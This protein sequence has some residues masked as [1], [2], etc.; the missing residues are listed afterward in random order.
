MPNIRELS[1]EAKLL[2][3]KKNFNEALPLYKSIWAESNIKNEWDGL[4]LAVC[5]KHLKQ[6]K[7]A[8]EICNEVQRLFPSFDKINTTF[9]WCIY[10]TEIGIEQITDKQ[11]LFLAGERIVKLSKQEDL[12]SNSENKFPCVRSLSIFKILQYLN[13]NEH[14]IAKDIL[15]WTEKLNP[16]LL[17]VKPFKF[18]KNGKEREIAPQKEQ[19]YSLRAKAFY[20]D[21]QF[22]ECI[23]FANKALI[24]FKNFHYDNNLWF[25][26]DIALSKA[27]LGDI[28]TALN[29]LK[30]ILT[31]KN[32]W[33]IQLEIAQ[34]FNKRNN[35]DEALKYA[36][37]AVLNF[38]DSKMK[39]KLYQLLAELLTKK[40]K[41]DIAKF[42]IELIY[43][44]RKSNKW[45]INDEL[46]KLLKEYEINT[47]IDLN[48]NEI[49][50]KLKPHWEQL[51]VGNQESYKGIIRTMISEGRAGFID[52]ENKH[53]YYF[54][55]KDFNG[56]NALAKQGQKVLFFLEDGYD[57]KKEQPT[58]I[59][60]N[61]R[62]DK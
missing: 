56:N 30:E 2:Y 27:A 50:N 13:S 36:I 10:Y 3:L 39:I 41:K 52:T 45:K 17:E 11:R 53:S 58:K 55:I 51:K 40:G 15:Y 54:S 33:F 43:H 29:I 35:T 28:D 24:T 26:R 1:T 23:E 59:A 46:N 60:T 21:K 4:R 7:Q 9:A 14:Y 12:S 44:I 49:L 31:R 34:I 25:K 6:Y 61:I 18:N 20:E 22:N 19:W 16:N 62:V 48:V 47:N 57:K 38:G 42:H 8:I 32:E 5:F 37:L